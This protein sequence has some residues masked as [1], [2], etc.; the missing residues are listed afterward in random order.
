ML[1]NPVTLLRG[2]PPTVRILVAGTF[3]NKIGSFIIPFLTIVLRREFRLSGTEVGAL[4]MAYGAGSLVSI[5]AGGVLTDR[6]GRRAT[7][8]LS[9]FG[10]GAIAV[11]LGFSPSLRVFAT[12]LILLGF[13]A[14]LY[15][16]AATAIIADLLP[17]AQ[18]A[19]GFAALRMAINLGFAVGMTVGGLLAD[20]SWRLLFVGDGLTTAIF[21][22]LVYFFIPETRPKLASPARAV[23]G[24]VAES[25][26]RD[27]VFLQAMA[28][29]FAFALIFFSHLTALPLT[30]TVNAGYP[31][32]LFGVL[33]GMNGLLI[34][35]FEV[36]VVHR[37][38]AW[39]RLRVAALGMALAGLGFGLSGV[40]LHWAWFLVTVV[41]WTAGEILSSPFKMAFVTDWAPPV[42][43]GRY[44]SLYQATWSVAFA[45]NPV[46]FLPL[47]ARL[48]DRRFWPVMVV[49]ASP[50]VFMLLRLDRLADR[51]ERLRGLAHDPVL[52]AEAALLAP[53]PLQG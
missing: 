36:S 20:W 22:A 48:G 42:L 28:V 17:S 13:V 25:P 6:L 1:R 49:V 33:V 21:G 37:L 10:S 12:L 3:I 34:A 51:P 44:L 16:P 8:L 9:F 29:S 43:R 46:L 4:L 15:R 14:D 5:L 23:A 2:L 50:A 26:W 30:M 27:G 24:L 7:L 53:A 35:V 38:R 40:V 45:L 41:I 39:R 19:V 47:Q 31:A 52:D 18:R 11:L 32:A